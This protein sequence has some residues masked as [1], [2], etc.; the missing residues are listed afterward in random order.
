MLANQMILGA[1]AWNQFQ[2]NRRWRN[3]HNHRR[4]SC[5]FEVTQRYFRRRWV[6]QQS[7]CLQE[8]KGP[9]IQDVQAGAAVL[10]AGC[11]IS[12]K[13][14]LPNVPTLVILLEW[15]GSI[16]WRITPDISSADFRL[17]TATKAV[18]HF[19]TLSTVIPPSL[20]RRTKNRRHTSVIAD[21]GFWIKTPSRKLLPVL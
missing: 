1:W 15:C 18:S 11:W 21:A 20:V 14:Q 2:S 5:I 13:E 7:S 8:Y 17:R 19:P 12:R 6:L 10:P 9:E 3:R 16:V 4:R